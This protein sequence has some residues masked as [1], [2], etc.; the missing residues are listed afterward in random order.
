MHRTAVIR[1][2]AAI[3]GA[4]LLV[5]AA[6]ALVVAGVTRGQASTAKTVEL[7]LIAGKT[8]ANG[9][10]N[11]NGYANGALREP[12]SL[13]YPDVF[14]NGL[15]GDMQHGTGYAIA[16]DLFRRQPAEG[17]FG[18]AL[19]SATLHWQHTPWLA[20]AT[21]VGGWI[22]VVLLMILI[23]FMDK[24][25]TLCHPSE[26]LALAVL[27]IVLIGQMRARSVTKGLISGG[28]GLMVSFVGYDP[29]TGIR[30]SGAFASNDTRRGARHKR[31]AGS[32]RPFGWLSTKITGPC[33][34]TCSAPETSIRLKKMRR[35][36]IV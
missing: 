15:I 14:M 28:L 17:S 3:A 7:S 32:M 18:R 34:G 8:P 23:P 5:S 21:T 12:T 33:G 11:F 25:T 29:I 36:K 10:F 30:K 9:S 4:V 20:T 35:S 6:L 2:A 16:P 24:L 31:N 13:L 1:S 19:A 26:F 22:G 27:A